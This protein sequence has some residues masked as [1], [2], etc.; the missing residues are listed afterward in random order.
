[1]PSGGVVKR[2]GQLVPLVQDLG[3]A[4]VRQAQMGRLAAFLTRSLQ[5]LPVGLGAASRLPWARCTWPSWQT[6]HEMG[7][8]AGRP[9]WAATR[10]CSTAKACFGELPRPAGRG[11]SPP[12][13][14]SP[15][16][17]E[18]SSRSP[19]PSSARA[20]EVV[21]GRALGVTA[22]LGEKGCA[23]TRSA[24]GHWPARWRP[25]GRWL[26]RLID[27]RAAPASARSAVVQQRP[28][29]LPPGRGWR[30]ATPGPGTAAAGSRPA[31]RAAPKASAAQSRPR[32]GR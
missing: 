24:R 26:V 25:P 20:C 4:H 9:A 8:L 16:P 10:R 18:L 3:Q 32:C 12:P 30:P 7:R 28:R 5:R 19:P 27:R 14:R 13:A 22:E 11:A 21:R 31:Q 2:G 29:S 6:P 17:V 1:M 15:P 23:G